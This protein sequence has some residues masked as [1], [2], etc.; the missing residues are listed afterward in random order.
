MRPDVWGAKQRGC[1][2]EWNDLRLIRPALLIMVGIMA[3]AQ[4]LLEFGDK[5]SKATIVEIISEKEQNTR[6][7]I[8]DRNDGKAKEQILKLISDSL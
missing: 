1:G 8:I 2:P 5:G 4:I 7:R 3:T 6:V